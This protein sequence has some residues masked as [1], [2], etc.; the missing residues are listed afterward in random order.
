MREYSPAGRRPGPP[1]GLVTLD[2]ARIVLPAIPRTRLW[3]IADAELWANL[4][5]AGELRVDPALISWPEWRPQY[6]WLRGQMARRIPGYGG[7]YPWWSWAA[8]KPDLRDRTH[9]NSPTGCALVRLALDV[10]TAEILAFDFMDWHI[11]LNDGFLSLSEAEDQAWDA[12]P[13]AER[14]QAA[15]EQSWER[16]F[17]PELPRDP[18]WSGPLTRVQAIFETLRRADVARVKPFR[19]RYAPFKG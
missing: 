13:A 17:A 18:D 14:T 2:G 3:M 7:S 12:L 5:E 8:P 9:H 15:M 10:P 6:D 1:G 11:P 4:Q 16:L 19:S